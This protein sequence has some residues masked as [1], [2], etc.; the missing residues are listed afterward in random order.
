MATALLDAPVVEEPQAPAKP[1]GLVATPL[2]STPVVPEPSPPSPS[3]LINAPAVEEPKAPV[4]AKGLIQ[5]PAVAEPGKPLVSTRTGAEGIPEAPPVDKDKLATQQQKN[6]DLERAKQAEIEA[7][8]SPDTPEKLKD[9]EAK[10][11]E[12]ESRYSTQQGIEQAKV[13]PPPPQAPGGVPTAEDLATRIPSLAQPETD[14]SKVPALGG[15]PTPEDLATRIPQAAQGYTSQQMA[16]MTRQEEERQRAAVLD[17][18]ARAAVPQSVDLLHESYGASWAAAAGRPIFAA[19]TPGQDVAQAAQVQ[20]Q[21]DK[22]WEPPEA[23]ADTTISHDDRIQALRNKFPNADALTTSYAKLDPEAQKALAPL[24]NEAITKTLQWN[25]DHQDQADVNAMVRGVGD[26]AT[27]LV[28]IG[29]GIL[30]L[31]GIIPQLGAAGI[32]T[33]QGLDVL[34]AVAQHKALTPQQQGV[35]RTIAAGLQLGHHETAQTFEDLI[36]TY[37]QLQNLQTGQRSDNPEQMSWRQI[38]ELPEAERTRYT[39]GR[40]DS[41]SNRYLTDKKMSEGALTD[42]SR[43]NVKAFTGADPAS[44]DDLAKKNIHVNPVAI[45]GGAFVTNMGETMPAFALAEGLGLDG[46]VS[47]AVGRGTEVSGQMMEDFGKLHKKIEPALVKGG[48]VMG[49]QSAKAVESSVL[50]ALTGGVTSVVPH[51]LIPGGKGNLPVRVGGAVGQWIGERPG[52]IRE[53]WL[54]PTSRLLIDHGQEL[55]NPVAN[56]GKTLALHGPAGALIRPVTAGVKGAVYALPFTAGPKTPEERGEILGAGAGLMAATATPKAA[57]DASMASLFFRDPSQYKTMNFPAMHYGTDYFGQNFDADHDAFVQT[58]SQLDQARINDSRG[59]LPN[60]EQYHLNNAAYQA[61]VAHLQANGY[62]PA[63]NLQSRGFNILRDPTTGKALILVN[64]DAPGGFHTIS[65]EIGHTIYQT[66]SPEQQDAFRNAAFQVNDPNQLAQWYFGHLLGKNVR[67]MDLP[68]EAGIA[69]GTQAYLPGLHG[70]TREHFVEEM[71]AETVAAL[72]RGHPLSAFVRDPSLFRRVQMGLGGVMEKM[73]IK[74]SPEEARTVLG[75]RPGLAQMWIMDKALRD[76]FKKNPVAQ[77]PTTGPA[78]PGGSGGRQ[79]PSPK[80]KGRQT[81]A[82]PKPTG[83]PAPVPPPPPPGGPAAP[84]IGPKPTGPKVT[85]NQPEIGGGATGAPQREINDAVQGLQTLKFAKREAQKMVA[86]ASGQTAAELIRNALKNHQIAQGRIEVPRAPQEAVQAQAPTVPHPLA[87][88]RDLTS[89]ALLRRAIDGDQQA[90]QALIERHG[91]NWIQAFEKGGEHSGSQARAAEFRRKYPE[92]AAEQDQRIKAGVEAKPEPIPK[93]EPTPKAKDLP[94]TTPTHDAIAARAYEISQERGGAPG[95]EQE[96]WAQAEKELRQRAI[97]AAKAR[98]MPMAG[99]KAQMFPEEEA[100][101]R[102]FVSPLHG[103][104]QFE[105]NDQ[106]MTFVAPPKGSSEKTMLE[107]NWAD[108]INNPEGTS[109][110]GDIINHPD[111]FKNYPGLRGLTVEM[112][113]DMR[114]RG[115]YQPRD[116]DHPGSL[117]KIMLQAISKETLAHEIQHDVQYR[118]NWPGGDSPKRIRSQMEKDPAIEQNLSDL[119]NAHYPEMGPTEFKTQQE[120]FDYMADR[121]EKYD[122]WRDEK[123]NTMASGAYLLS[124]GEVEARAAGKR[125]VQTIKPEY[126]LS[127]EDQLREEQLMTKARVDKAYAKMAEPPTPKAAFMPE[128][129]AAQY[130]SPNVEEGTGLPGALAQLGSEA[131]RRTREYYQKVEDAFG[132]GGKVV[133]TIGDWEGTKEGSSWSHDDKDTLQSARAKVALKGLHSAQKGT[134]VFHFDEA[135]PDGHYDID[136]PNLDHEQVDKLITKHGFPAS[137]VFETSGGLRAHLIDP[138]RE[139]YEHAAQLADEAGSRS[140]EF[141]RGTAAFD[142]GDTRTEAA[143]AYRRILAESGIQTRDAERGLP[144]RGD[145]TGGRHPLQALYDEAEDSFGRHRLAAGPKAAF[146]PDVAGAE[147]GEEAAARKAWIQ[148]GT[149][150]PYFRRWFGKSKVVDA[151]GDPQVVYHGTNMG[152]DTFQRG[153]ELSSTG[154]KSGQEGFFF[155]SKPEEAEQ[156]AATGRTGKVKQLTL[157]LNALRDQAS[158]LDIEHQWE[159]I[160]ALQDRYLALEKE[161][162]RLHEEA[163]Q[164]GDYLTAAQGAN[165]MPAYLSIEK[166]YDVDMQGEGRPQEAVLNQMIADAK[167]QGFDGLIMRNTYDQVFDMDRPAY[168]T[169]DIYMAFEP[170]QIKSATGNVGTFGRA[171][172]RVSFMPDIPEAPKKAKK[173]KAPA[174]VDAPKELRETLMTPEE[175][176]WLADAQQ[177]AIAGIEKY[178]ESPLSGI[179]YASGE[180]PF[181]QDK[182]TKAQVAAF[183]DGLAQQKLDFANPEHQKL[184]ADAL[185]HDILRRLISDPESLGWYNRVLDGAMQ[186]IGRLNPKVL[187]DPV[188]NLIMRLAMAITSQNQKVHPNFESAYRA[189]LYWAKTGEMP[190][191]TKFF[192]GATKADA[193]IANFTK[194]NDLING[195]KGNHSEFEELLKTPMTVGEIRDKFKVKIPGEAVGYQSEASMMLG[196]KI[197]SFFN[198]LSKL[199]HTLTADLWFTR[200]M[201]RMAGRMMGFSKWALARIEE[202]EAEGSDEEAVPKEEATGPSQLGKLRTLIN[203][204][205]IENATKE[206]QQTML[207]EISAIEAYRDD[208]EALDRDKAIELM[209]TIR[210]WAKAQHKSYQKSTGYNDKGEFLQTYGHK[211]P[212]HLLGKNIDLNFQDLTDAP[213]NGTERENFRDIMKEVQRNLASLGINI[214]HADSQAVLWYLEQDLFARAKGRKAGSFSADYLD[215]AYALRQKYQGKTP[216]EFGKVP[217]PEPPPEA[218][219]APKKTR[220]TK[221]A[222][223]PEVPAYPTA[224]QPILPAM[225]FPPSVSQAQEEERKRQTGIPSAVTMRSAPDVRRGTRM[226][227]LQRPS[228]EYTLPAQQP[229]QQPSESGDQTGV[230]NYFIK[231]GEQPIASA[232]DPRLTT[233]SVGGQNWRVHRD[234]APAFQGFL[235][236]L[237]AAGAPIRSDGGWAYR[238]IA[239]GGISEHA[240]GGAIDLNQEGRDQVTP[241]FRHWLV[242]HPG[243]LAAAENR[244]H[245][246]GGERFGDLGHFE[247][248]GVP[249][250]QGAGSRIADLET[251]RRTGMQSAAR[252]LHEEGPSDVQDGVPEIFGFRKGQDSE[253]P[254]LARLRASGD[255]RGVQ[256]LAVEGLLKRAIDAGSGQFNDPAVK[257][258]VMSLAHMRGPGGARTILNAVGGD[259]HLV[260]ESS[261]SLDPQAVEAIKHMSRAEFMHRVEV[262]RTVY[263]QKFHGQEYWNRFGKGLSGRY[264]RER[265]FYNSLG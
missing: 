230:A 256:G 50:N 160:D 171:E 264:S 210:E 250:G 163:R 166:P 232:D 159:Q 208:P 242:S 168:G 140:A 225:R 102:V 130:V 176:A 60:V 68:E 153:L 233:V 182:M 58:Q 110:L 87:A 39:Q 254:E 149:R 48:R 201:N 249:V 191:D 80:P 77:R 248:G 91:A 83:G 251:K 154:T 253:Y 31:P 239:G 47:K 29:K 213:R 177:R 64:G 63:G 131:H 228:Q 7:L 4:Q 164:S 112:R 40:M 45:Q 103:K 121:G 100:A 125:A 26:T 78:P 206:Q 222:A 128:T 34:G 106:D 174:R 205:K 17:V 143:Q 199:Y 105:I 99:E 184:M 262:A 94:P 169:S 229:Q 261:P 41:L 16:E 245:I 21:E 238:N 255:E 14:L 211:T 244:W 119:F 132:G 32:T 144:V 93:A 136:F 170:D 183:F 101:G 186:E 69:N 19:P 204:G 157:E 135:G 236:E 196:P 155:S 202:V 8:G 172:P 138:G 59:L 53:H 6:A 192:G 55:Q 116:F 124:P 5:A 75:I 215:A 88:H 195:F 146:M 200:T 234:A 92:Q 223:M 61:A 178:P 71:A 3:P 52:W 203:K 111:L 139:N 189:Y 185:T 165:I 56:A 241:A 35:L 13:A 79:G 240:F 95:H 9:Y 187:E 221:A 85:N 141:S 194:V 180:Q 150:S 218:P 134:A 33:A 145:E 175:Q 190:T 162:D 108:Y 156:Y 220:K 179:R 161:R 188:H 212:N 84:A 148:Q 18:T 54:D 129:G 133:P 147:P 265:E 198:N 86:G 49:Q 263:D 38:G 46:L 247:W 42:E 224:R 114:A 260:A 36:N 115:A 123:L 137:T 72:L 117:P 98:F 27:T 97:K 257:A 44:L 51:W 66:L 127:P 104:K 207:N 142:G 107:H 24:Y 43:R 219:S 10:K 12:I 113:P 37:M 173:A 73:G 1:K 243:A 76:Y 70:Y 231:S 74:M 216:D 214:E 126:R 62:L 89:P 15:K 11:Q 109:R 25:I 181:P 152:F 158:R 151:D 2:L 258:Q 28:N 23:V 209:P 246:Y 235:N 197:G 90:V 65:H 30:S 120:Y 167:R 67:Y 82:A 96:D 227:P 122:Q 193:M 259:G 217:E 118:E 20:A 252:I 81:A 226:M 22:K 57:R 237:A